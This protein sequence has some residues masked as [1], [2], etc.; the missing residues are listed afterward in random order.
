MPENINSVSADAARDSSSF[1]PLRSPAVFVHSPVTT[2]G[3]QTFSRPGGDCLGTPAKVSGKKVDFNIMKRG[4]Y[5]HSSSAYTNGLY[6]MNTC[7]IDMSIVRRH[8]SVV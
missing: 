6:N 7:A 2:D 8:A 5:E 4:G 3:P 1:P